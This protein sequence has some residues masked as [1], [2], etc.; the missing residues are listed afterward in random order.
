V[1]KYREDQEKL[2]ATGMDRLI[3]QAVQRALVA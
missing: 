1:L 3:Q 2:A